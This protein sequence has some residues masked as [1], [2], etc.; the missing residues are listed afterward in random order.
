[1]SNHYAWFQFGYSLSPGESRILQPSV[2]PWLQQNVHSSPSTKATISMM[3]YVMCFMLSLCVCQYVRGKDAFFFMLDISLWFS[4]KCC[5]FNSSLLKSFTF[6][7][8]A[9]GR[10]HCRPSVWTMKGLIICMTVNM[11]EIWVFLMLCLFSCFLCLFLFQR[12]T[13]IYQV[14]L[15]WETCKYMAT[16]AIICRF[17]ELD[18]IEHSIDLYGQRELVNWLISSLWSRCL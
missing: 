15:T 5:C 3:L 13:A 16:F 12:S 10:A 18:S 1:M 17:L 11:Q 6:K 7:W 4:T 14:S 8:H 9:H 2:N